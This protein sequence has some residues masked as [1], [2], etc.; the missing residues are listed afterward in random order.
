MA[1]ISILV[2]KIRTNNELEW[3][4]MYACPKIWALQFL[5]HC[6]KMGGNGPGVLKKH[7]F[8]CL[9]IN[10]YY[11]NLPR[12]CGEKFELEFEKRS[13]TKSCLGRIHFI[14]FIK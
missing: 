3:N 5:V 12:R 1:N 13:T 14:N 7:E 10:R 9:Q 2:A 6:K 8:W 11:G 4:E